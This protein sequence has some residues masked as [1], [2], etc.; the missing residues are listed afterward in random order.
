MPAS[1]IGD[2]V[3]VYFPMGTTITIVGV[4]LPPTPGAV[5]ASSV[6]HRP[7]NEHPLACA[8]I[9]QSGSTVAFGD[10]QGFARVGDMI[11]LYIPPGCFALGRYHP[12]LARPFPSPRCRSSMASP[13][14]LA[15][16]ARTW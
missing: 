8:G 15:R 3:S 12:A 7:C 6:H 11:T 5:S 9:I 4:A 10:T 1:R 2:T 16:A 13:H 14:S